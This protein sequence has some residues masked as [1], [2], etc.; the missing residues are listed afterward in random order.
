MAK[1]L[2]FK[3][4]LGM[5]RLKATSFTR[6]EIDKILKHEK[7]KYDLDDCLILFG[8]LMVIVAVYFKYFL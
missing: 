4:K 6:E 1:I 3:S 8:L 2:N 5:Q 7:P